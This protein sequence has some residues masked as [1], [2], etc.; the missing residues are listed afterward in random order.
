M[1]DSLPSWHLGLLITIK[2]IIKLRLMYVLSG[3]GAAIVKLFRSRLVLTICNSYSL[4][5][6]LL[7]LLSASSAHGLG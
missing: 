4:L 6:L 2:P 3:E 1:E 5:M 7:S